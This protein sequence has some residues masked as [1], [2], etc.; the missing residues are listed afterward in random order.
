M[1]NHF[2]VS[3]TDVS[4]P[5]GINSDP[6]LL[7]KPKIKHQ[8][9]NRNRQSIN[10]LSEETRHFF[11]QYNKRPK[12]SFREGNISPMPLNNS[13]SKYSKHD[14]SHYLLGNSVGASTTVNE[15]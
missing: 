7:E 15:T 5:F 14:L 11:G 6:N 13:P 1:A 4:S 9:P 3:S 2:P 12:K 8:R 10:F